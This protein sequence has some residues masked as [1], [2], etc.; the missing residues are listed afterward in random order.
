MENVIS[1]AIAYRD[2]CTNNCASLYSFGALLPRL[3]LMGLE[4]RLIL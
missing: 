4:K 2:H 3:R 1:G